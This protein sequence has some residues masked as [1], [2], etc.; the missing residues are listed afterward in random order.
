[1]F[2][3]V[4][5]GSNLPSSLSHSTEL[6]PHLLSTASVK[7]GGSQGLGGTGSGGQESRVQRQVPLPDTK[8]CHCPKRRQAAF[9]LLTP[10]PP[11]AEQG[12][13]SEL[14]P[15]RKGPSKPQTAGLPTKAA[16][17]IQWPG[18]RDRRSLVQIHMA[19][20]GSRVRRFFEPTR[21]PSWTWPQHNRHMEHVC[22]S[23][24]SC[25]HSAPGQPAAPAP[26][27]QRP[28]SSRL[29]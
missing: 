16:T 29:P 23:H 25:L 28:I 3:S 24:A 17:A 26:P 11:S 22:G 4:R 15:S 19:R 6:K 14:H 12:I 2:K 27:H 10:H 13:D 20:G 1:M 8:N 7:D 18:V 21:L 9:A 5:P